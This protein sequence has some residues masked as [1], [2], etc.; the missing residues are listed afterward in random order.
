MS[1]DDFS[2]PKKRQ[3][4]FEVVKKTIIKQRNRIKSLNSTVRRLKSRITNLN[5]LLKMLKE[6]ALITESSES[7]LRV[8]ISLFFLSAYRCV[9]LFEC[10]FLKYIWSITYELSTSVQLI[11]FT[12]IK[13]LRH[14]LKLFFI[15]SSYLEYTKN[16]FI[17]N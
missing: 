17:E 11:D 1:T 6:R 16:L 14:Q 15:S 8:S 12:M 9:L 3:R 7:T 5:S 10:R 4:N 2:S 13:H